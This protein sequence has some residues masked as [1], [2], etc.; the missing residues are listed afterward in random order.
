[1]S[2]NLTFTRPLSNCSILAKKVAFGLYPKF[3]NENHVARDLRTMK[4]RDFL[5]PDACGVPTVGCQV[6]RTAPLRLFLSKGK[7]VHGTPEQALGL[8]PSP[9]PWR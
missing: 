5:L 7:S 2:L 4:L 9:E 1:V 3:V 8:S 6:A